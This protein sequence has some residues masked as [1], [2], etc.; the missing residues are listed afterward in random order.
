MLTFERMKNLF[1]YDEEQNPVLD[2]MLCLIGVLTIC[3]AGVL[4]MAF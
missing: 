3:A 2:C 1:D 4:L